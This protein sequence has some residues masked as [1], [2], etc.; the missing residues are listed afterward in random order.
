MQNA[1]ALWIMQ[2]VVTVPWT[3]VSVCAIT[4]SCSRL[5]QLFFSSIIS[6][7]RLTTLH[8]AAYRTPSDYSSAEINCIIVLG[9]MMIF[10][11]IFIFS[12]FSLLIKEARIFVSSK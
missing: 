6:V 4:T 5:F 1:S 9:I 12:L 11:N 10:W 2:R 7:P 8:Y 3:P